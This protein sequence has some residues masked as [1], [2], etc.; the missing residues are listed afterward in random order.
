MSKCNENSTV[1]TEAGYS[2]A[3]R[4]Y[5]DG[6]E[7]EPLLQLTDLMV[8]TRATAAADY[9]GN[10]SYCRSSYPDGGEQCFGSAFV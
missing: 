1:R 5:P 7:H 3:A 9:G 6:G 2:A 10:K 4:D 8:E